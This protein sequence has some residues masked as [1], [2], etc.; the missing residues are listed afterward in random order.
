MLYCWVFH[1]NW[2]EN[3][4]FL[5]VPGC[6]SDLI[7]IWVVKQGRC[8]W[9]APGQDRQATPGPSV[10]KVSFC[11]LAFVS[12]CILYRDSNTEHKR[13]RIIAFFFYPVSRYPHRYPQLPLVCLS[14]GVVMTLPERFC[15]TKNTQLLCKCTYVCLYSCLTM[16]PLPFMV[17]QLLNFF[18]KHQFCW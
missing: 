12:V 16:G 7:F 5:C 10:Y 2:L 6:Y 4:F 11:Q 15:C 18:K 13:L 14:L 17:T 8:K 9:R 3:L 1:Q